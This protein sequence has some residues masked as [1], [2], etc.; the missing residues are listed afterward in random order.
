MSDIDLDASD[1][2]SDQDDLSIGESSFGER[3]A[4]FSVAAS[5]VTMMLGYISKA[6][7]GNPGARFVISVIGIIILFAGLCL[8]VA[9]LVSYNQRPRP[10]IL[11]RAV[12]GVLFNGL[13]LFAVAYLVIAHGQMETKLTGRWAM[14]VPPG[15][16]LRSATLTLD[17]NGKFTLETSTATQSVAMAG[18]WSVNSSDVLGVKPE[19]VSPGA[20]TSVVGTPIAV[21]KVESID[22]HQM[23]LDTDRGEET[24]A[25]IE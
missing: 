14:N 21:G 19:Q 9:A 20:N 6:N 18:D 4:G 1:D 12:G 25:R 24:Y 23:T 11:R 13:T 8:G 2:V 5:F 16:F 17:P 7:Q 3:A 15:S 10:G 22:D